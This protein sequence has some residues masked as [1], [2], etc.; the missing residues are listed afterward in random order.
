MSG[1]FVKSVLASATIFAVAMSIA[2]A[3][4][5]PGADLPAGTYR[6][7][8]THA[9]LVFQVNHLGFSDYTGAFEDFD[10]MLELDPP[11]ASPTR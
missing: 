4:E 9:S 2:A 11:W 8:K 1:N 5:A 7:D 6:L 10:V 3:Q